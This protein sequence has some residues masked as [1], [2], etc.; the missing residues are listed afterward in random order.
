MLL[1]FLLTIVRK[2]VI[3]M[4]Y[5]S[6][7]LQQQFLIEREISTYLIHASPMQRI[8]NG[9]VYGHHQRIVRDLQSNQFQQFWELLSERDKH[10]ILTLE[11]KDIMNQAR[12][13]IY[14]FVI[15]YVMMNWNSLIPADNPWHVIREGS[16]FYI[17][18]SK[19]NKDLILS[20]IEAGSRY[21]YA[22]DP[23][24][25]P[26]LSHVFCEE[27]HY[28]SS[29]FDETLNACCLER[30]RLY[31]CWL[32]CDRMEYAF[33][34]HQKEEEANR[35]AASLLSEDIS[36]NESG[37]KKKKKKR[38]KKKETEILTSSLNEVK[39]TPEP[40]PIKQL[41]V[42]TNSTQPSDDQGTK[43]TVNSINPEK[44]D[45]SMPSVP[46]EPLQSQPSSIRNLV[47]R[48]PTVRPDIQRINRFLL[49]ERREKPDL[50]PLPE[51]KRAR[52]VQETKP[53]VS[54]R[55]VL[56]R[57]DPWSLPDTES[58]FSTPIV[59]NSPILPPEGA[60]ITMILN[61]SASIDSEVIEPSQG[62][63]PSPMLMSMKGYEGLEEYSTPPSQLLQQ[64]LQQSIPEQVNWYRFLI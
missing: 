4:C 29:S 8:I 30:F 32:L 58:S 35:M 18:V 63:E 39:S 11:N 48:K 12:E 6:M 44:V 34:M 28:E 19:I 27:I 24:P 51:R 22:I 43:I 31:F 41:S 17:E 21:D 10:G 7:Q 3:E 57:P 62:D 5:R 20:I 16:I 46:S 64:T 1:R 2:D 53:F 42:K 25:A 9:N 54:L 23:T 14:W 15:R 37:K 26:E 45:D 49:G 47:T 36:V 55:Q 33:Q 59:D 52:E 56:A 50:P 61:Q 40:A 38:G 13:S 60:V